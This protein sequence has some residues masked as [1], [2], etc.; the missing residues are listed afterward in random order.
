M[1][2]FYMIRY[3][4]KPLKRGWCAIYKN[5][6]PIEKNKAGVGYSHLVRKRREQIMK[7]KDPKKVTAMLSKQSSWYKEIDAIMSTHR[8][9]R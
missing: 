3:T 7:T 8:H 1:K 6:I 9:I 2:I 4:A 5:Q